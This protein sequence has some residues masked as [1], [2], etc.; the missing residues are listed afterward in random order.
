M[1][2]RAAPSRS[3]GAS[4][5]EEGI[6]LEGDLA[7]KAEHRP[8][9]RLGLLGPDDAT[10]LWPLESGANRSA[11]VTQNRQ[12]KVWWAKSDAA[13]PQK[14]AIEEVPR[15]RWFVIDRVRSP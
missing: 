13:E 14:T 10:N 2:R 1:S 5:Q 8:R 4:W 15:G 6:D 11:G 7:Y 9:R 12:Q 3:S